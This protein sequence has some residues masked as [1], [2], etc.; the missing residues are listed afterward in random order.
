MNKRTRNIILLVVGFMLIATFALL[1]LPPVV[2]A[3]P[4]RYRVALQERV[5]VAGEVLEGVIEQV[6][7]VATALPAAAVGQ[8]DNDVD[9]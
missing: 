4:G 5:P 2:E 7:P 6:A 9:I 8:T 1:A 3:I